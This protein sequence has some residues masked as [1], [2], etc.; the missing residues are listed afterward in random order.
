MNLLYNSGVL[1]WGPTELGTWCPQVVDTSARNLSLI[2]ASWCAAIL[3][4]A[5]KSSFVTQEG[6]FWSNIHL[7]PWP[8]QRASFRWCCWRWAPGCW[9]VWRAK[10]A[11]SWTLPLQ[12]E[13]RWP[14]VASRMTS[15]P[16]RR[17]W[18]QKIR[19]CCWSR[20]RMCL[21]KSWDVCLNVVF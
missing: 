4:S 19:H 13:A 12:E 5:Q 17:L 3:G 21:G 1:K 2:S 20:P 9:A 14:C 6:Q 16:G 15:M 7:T 8:V 10:V 11:S 18:A